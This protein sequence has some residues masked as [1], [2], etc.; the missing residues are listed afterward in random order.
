VSAPAGWYDDPQSPG[1]Q[2]YWD[3]QQWTEQRQPAASVPP[4]PPTAPVTHTAAAPEKRSH[5]TRNVILAVI[6]VLV[7][8]MGGCT[9]ALVAVGGNA[10]NEAIEKTN[11]ELAD[12]GDTPAPNASGKD[13]PEPTQEL[14]VSQQNALESAESYLSFSA[15]S[16]AG[17]IDQLSSKAGEGFPK[18][19]AVWAVKHV[20]VDWNKEAVEAAR[21]YLDFTSFSRS[22]LIQQLSSPAGD[23]FTKAQATYAANKVGL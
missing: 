19:D 17:L 15:F 23:Q 16:E 13:D 10:V 21:S 3:G 2:R 7:L 5:T 6:G 9:I 14:T 4:P 22:G 1:Q 20:E 11:D 8:L 12:P 18:A